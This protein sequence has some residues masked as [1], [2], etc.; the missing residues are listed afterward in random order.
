MTDPVITTVYQALSAR[1][2]QTV[3][4]NSR[5]VGDS[6]GKA[7]WTGETE[8]ADFQVGVWRSTCITQQQ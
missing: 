2:F 1:G 3:R 8:A 4:Y 6:G 7:S 5:G